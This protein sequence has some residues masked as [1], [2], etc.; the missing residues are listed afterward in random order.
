MQTPPCAV[1][2][3]D[4]ELHPI[5]FQESVLFHMTITSDISTSAYMALPSL[6]MKVG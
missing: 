3:S 1:V 4:T 5:V 6:R 2:D